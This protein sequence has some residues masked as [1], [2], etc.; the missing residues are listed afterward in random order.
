MKKS[1]SLSGEWTIASIF[2]KSSIIE[3][4]ISLLRGPNGSSICSIFSLCMASNTLEKSM[5]N[6]VA[7]RFFAQTLLMIQWTVTICDVVDLFLLKPFWFFLRS[8]LISSRIRLRSWALWNLAAIPVRVMP[9]H[10]NIDEKVNCSVAKA[11]W[12]F[13]H[14]Q[15]IQCMRMNRH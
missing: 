14:Q 9:H 12:V 5:N 6:S 15:S 10:A 13:R 1:V 7:S 2:L 3:V 8:F 4:T 11:R